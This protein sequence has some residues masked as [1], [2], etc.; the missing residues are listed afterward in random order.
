[1]ALVSHPL[2]AALALADQHVQDAVLVR[3]AL[4]VPLVRDLVVRRVL[5][6]IRSRVAKRRGV[7]RLAML[8]REV[9][10]RLRALAYCLRLRLQAPQRYALAQHPSR[11]RPWSL[12]R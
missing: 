6:E 4:H 12:A 9:P 7:Q 11:E 5:V 2:R 1:M 3:V 10:V 8:Q